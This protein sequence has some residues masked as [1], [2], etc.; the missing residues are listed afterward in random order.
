DGAVVAVADYGHAMPHVA[1]YWG[2][3]AEAGDGFGFRARVDLSSR[4]PGRHW[5]GLVL[6]GADGSVERWP[7]QLLVIE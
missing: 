3:P 5:L 2:L 1:D 7:E 6:H 4:A